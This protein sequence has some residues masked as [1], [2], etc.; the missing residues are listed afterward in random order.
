MQQGF[1][2]GLEGSATRAPKLV[3]RDQR[4]GTLGARVADR[5]LE[6]LVARIGGHDPRRANRPAQR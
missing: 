2:E 5:K 3:F 6:Q 1:I 4:T